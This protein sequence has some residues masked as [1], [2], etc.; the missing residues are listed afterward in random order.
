MLKKHET[1]KLF[2]NKYLYRLGIRNP[3]ASIFRNKNFAYASTILDQLQQ[4]YEAGQ[5]LQVTY[6]MRVQPIRIQDFKDAQILYNE[7]TRYQDDYILRIENQT[8]SVYS[9][10]KQWLKILSY[11]IKN[12]LD[13][14]EPDTAFVEYLKQNINTI[15]VE[16]TFG[17]DYKIT[18]GNDR[19]PTT[20]AQWL[21]VN[22]DKVRITDK[23]I[24][25][26]ENKYFTTGRYFYLRSENVLMLVK[27]I[28][29]DSIQRIDKLV[30]KQDIDK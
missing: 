24:Q 9:N 26:I 15:I 30:S 19:C 22:R 13:F 2:Y 7:L 27:L 25:D 28:I 21:R 12:V 14:S 8:V 11:K 29:L 3:L 1:T 4:D 23:L 16:D 10:D 5:P 6:V 18:L 20:F 17:Y